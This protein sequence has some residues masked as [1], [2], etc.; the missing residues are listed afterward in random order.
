MK[1]QS[2]A[3][4]DVGKQV[5]A[6][7]L[8]AAAEKKAGVKKP[9]PAKDALPFRKDSRRA[10]LEAKQR[11]QATIANLAGSKYRCTCK[12][13]AE[14]HKESCKLYTQE[15]STGGMVATSAFRR[16]SSQKR[17]DSI[18]R[19]GCGEFGFCA[20]YVWSVCVIVLEND[21]SI[22]FDIA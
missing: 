21:N 18:Q 14:F 4:G 22:S 8:K 9:L 7:K 3:K 20:Q 2:S 13:L 11:V 17:S 5:A 16:L 15:G 1:K 19:S 6:K 12:S 10:D